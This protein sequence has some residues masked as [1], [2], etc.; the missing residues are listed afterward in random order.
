MDDVVD[1]LMVQWISVYILN[2]MHNWMM[3]YATGWCNTELD[4]AVPVDGAMDLWMIQFD[5]A[6]DDK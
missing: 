6:V 3:Q 4:Y 2:A 1:K 5:D